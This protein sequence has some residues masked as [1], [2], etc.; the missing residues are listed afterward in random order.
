MTQKDMAN[1]QTE[2]QRAISQTVVVL[3]QPQNRLPLFRNC[4]ETSPKPTLS[5]RPNPVS[6]LFCRSRIRKFPLVLPHRRRCY[7]N[8]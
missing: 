2:Q 5:P 3:P 6:I 8:E 7:R 4:L 1:Q